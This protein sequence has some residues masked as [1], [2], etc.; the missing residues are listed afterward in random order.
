MGA[1]GQGVLRREG[2]DEQGPPGAEEAAQGVAQDLGAQ[3]GGPPELTS[4]I[5]TVLTSSGQSRSR[6]PR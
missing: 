3:A 6:P 2:G 5:G 1:G 4:R